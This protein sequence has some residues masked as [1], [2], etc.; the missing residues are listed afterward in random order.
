MRRLFAQMEKDRKVRLTEYDHFVYEKE[1]KSFLPDKIIDLY[2]HIGKN[3]FEPLAKSAQ[4]RKNTA[5]IHQLNDYVLESRKQ[6]GYPALY[7]SFYD[8]PIDELEVKVK[9][10]GF[11]GWKPYLNQRPS[12]IPA[13]ET[14]IFDFLTRK[15]LKA[16]DRNCWIIMMH[17]PRN[18][19]LRNQ[20]NLAQLMEIEEKFPNLKLVVAH[21][22]LKPVLRR[23][24]VN[25]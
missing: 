23:W 18:M 13:D 8:M 4:L 17:I 25:A 7:R 16:A 19:R 21:M 6:Y 3:F 15:Q 9:A 22:P 5:S 12:Y 14:R 11:L 24:A 1:L 10:G 2:A 20:V